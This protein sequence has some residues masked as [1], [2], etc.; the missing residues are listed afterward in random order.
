MN[1]QLNTIMNLYGYESYDTDYFETND[2]KGLREEML[3]NLPYGNLRRFNFKNYPLSDIVSAGKFV[4]DKHFGNLDLRVKYSNGD[5]FESRLIAL[6]GPNSDP[7]KNDDIISYIENQIE[8]VRVTD[9]PIHLNTNCDIPNGYTCVTYFY[10]IDKMNE[11]YF[12]KLPIC[13][14]EIGIEGMCNEN[15]KCM[16]VHEMA[17]ALI[18]RH[19]KNIK[20]LLNTETFSI[21]MERVAANDLD[22]SGDLLDM[23]MFYRIVQ[24]KNDMLHMELKKFNEKPFI[25]LLENQRYLISTLLATSLFDTYFKGSNRLKKEIDFE[26]GKVISGEAI[27]EDVLDNYEASLDNGTKIMKRQIKKYQKEIKN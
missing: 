10:E 9:I 22:S 16:Y 20:N 4:I 2:Y 23:K 27:L 19:K 17:H 1:K 14:K 13:T 6:F 25:E 7:S 11:D 5:D 21:F 3:N 26:L 12:K 18:N 15:I 8:L 24:C